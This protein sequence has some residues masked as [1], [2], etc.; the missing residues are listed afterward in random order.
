LGITATA[1]NDQRGQIISNG[2]LELNAG[3]V[4][5][6]SANTI[7]RQ[8]T[9]DSA[10]FS[11]R[12]GEI[13]QTGTAIASITSTGALDN[14]AGSIASNGDTRINAQSLNNQGGA[15]Q[16]TGAAN[17]NVLTSSA[18]D[19]SAGGSMA[20]GG[21][22]TLGASS[23]NNSQGQISEGGRLSTLASGATTNTQGLMAANGNASLT[24]ANLDNSQGT[25]ASVQEKVNVTT[26]GS[27]VNDS[28]RIQAAGD[29]ALRN[30]GLSNSQVAGA[31]QAGSITGS[32]ITIETNGQ[33]LN[34][35]GGTIA[36]AQAATLQTGALNNDAGLIQ[37]GAALSLDTQGQT[38]RNTNAAGYASGAGGITAQG[39]LA[40]NSGDM[41][42]D[43][44][45]IGA[46]GAISASSAKVSNSAGG[47]IVGE[48][49]IDFASTGFDNRGGQVQALG[50]VRLDAAA[51]TIDNTGSLVRSAGNTTLNAAGLINS[52]SG[53]TSQGIEGNNVAITANTITNDSGA[54][55]ADS[56]AT[57]TSSGVVSNAGGLISAGNA[58]TLQDA[59]AAKTLAITNGT[60]TI[61]GG[62]SAS[63]NAASLSSDGKLLSKGDLSLALS[64]GF[65]NSGEVTANGSATISTLGNIA[66]SGKLQAGNT[67]AVTA[68]TIDNAATGDINAGTTKVT[69]A[70]VLTNRGVIDGITTEVNAGTLNNLGTGRMYGDQLSIAADTLNNTLES[71]TAATIAARNRLDIG[72]QTINNAEHALI[73]S[74]GDMAIGGNLDADRH[75]TGQADAVNNASAT[76]E[77]LGNLV[78]STSQLNN[79]DKHF[80]YSMQQTSVENGVTE[81]V[82]PTLYRVFTRTTISPVAN[83]GDPGNILAGGDIT[84]HSPNINNHLSHIVA[85]GVLASP[86][87]PLAD[88]GADGHRLLNTGV[89]AQK[90]VRDS[91]TT[92]A[93]VH[94]PES[95]ICWG[96]IT[97]DCEAAHDEWRTGPYDITSQST[98]T[99]RQ[100][101]PAQGSG[102][103]PPAAATPNTSNDTS[104]AGVVVA[105]VTPGVAPVATINAPGAPASVTG[106]AQIVRTSAPSTQLPNTSLFHVSSSPANGFLV[107]TDPRFANYKT[108]VGSDYLLKALNIDP[109]TLHKRLGDGF[110]EQ[111]L[112]R[113]QVTKLT[114]QRFAGDYSTDEAQ[115]RALMDNGATYAKAHQ[116][117]PG[118]ALTPAQMAQLTSDIVWL[119][120]REVT[121]PDGSKTQAL[122]PQVYVRVQPGDLDGSGALLAGRE[123]NINT[124]GDLTNSGTI[125]GRTVV[126]LSAENVQN[127]G[128]RISGDA[129]NVAARNDLDNIGGQI[130]AKSSLAVNAG[131]DLNL[132]STTSSATNQI[133]SNT[134]SR[135]G[136]DRVAGL[137]VSKPGGT[138]LASA[139]RDAN[140]VGGVIQSQGSA[141]V[142]AGNNLNLKT[143]TTGNANSVVWDANNRVSDSQS[144]EL[145]SQ[146]QA[147]GNL[148][149]IAGQDLNAR[150]A[151]MQAG[152]ALQ[153]SA[154]HDVNLT[155]G[156]ATQSVDE[157][158][159]VKRQGFLS[160]NTATSRSTRDDSTAQVSNLAGNSVTVL[161]GNN[162]LLEGTQ[163]TAQKDALVYAGNQLIVSAARDSSNQSASSETLSRGLH[164]SLGAVGAQ[165]GTQGGGNATSS[166]TSTARG[167]QVSSAQGNASL[168]GASL[169]AVEGASLSAA[170]GTASITGGSV[171]VQGAVN[172]SSSTTSSTERGAKINGIGWSKTTE[173]INHKG[174]SSTGT[175]QTSLA[176]T[177]LSGQNASIVATD[178][179]AHIAGTRITT[180]GTLTLGASGTLHLDGQ[181][182]EKISSTQSQSR[183]LVY[184]KMKD[185]GSQ[186]QSTEYNQFHA[187]T[188]QV[189][190]PRISAQI[191]SKDSAQQLAQ[192]PGMQWVGQLTNDPALEGKVNWTQLQDA[193]RDWNY[194]QQGLTPEGAA[195]V[196]VVVAFFTYGAASSAGGAVAAGAGFTG[197]GATVVA[198]ATTAAITTLAAQAAVATL[199]H[200]DDPGAALKELGSSANTR[201][202]VTAMLTGG[203][204]GSLNLTPTGSPTVGG[205]AQPFMTQLGQNLQAGVA[206]SLISTAINGGSLED[207]LRNAI[208][209]AFID[210]GA[211]QGA[212]AIGEAGLDAFTN[213]VAHAIAGCV[214]GAARG[215]ASDGC[216]AGALG[217]A[218]GEASAEW[219]GKRDD[220]VQ[221]AAMM[222]AIGAA[223][224]GGDASQIN[225][226]SQTGGNAAANNYLKH[227]EASRL[228]ALLDK[229]LVGRCDSA[230][231]QEISSLQTLDH[232]RNQ[233]LDNCT[234]VASAACDTA[235]QAV[236]SA[237]A[238]YV[239]QNNNSPDLTYRTEAGE[240]VSLALGTLS[241]VPSAA[242]L[243]LLTSIKDGIVAL[244]SAGYTAFNALVRQ[245]PQAQQQVKE[246]AGAAWAF[247][248]EPANW[249]ELMGA[250]SGADRERLAKA[251]E[252]GDGLAVGQLLGAQVANLPVGGGG[253]GTIKKIDTLLEA[254]AAAKMAAL[255][256]E[257]LAVVK[258]NVGSKGSWEKAINGGLE[259]KAAYVL[260]NGHTYVTDTSGRV[261][262][263]VGEL[264]LRKMDRNTY[265][266]CITGKCGDVGDQGGHLIAATLGGAGDRINLVPQS[267]TLNNG[268]WK[269]MENEFKA[270]MESGKKV[271]IKID[272]GYPPG[273]GV[274]PDQFRVTTVIDGKTLPPR[275]FNQ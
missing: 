238:E 70:D 208:T 49:G 32:D 151:T 248:S 155:A 257:G 63:V 141:Q 243:G 152:Q 119:V 186:T 78:I 156:A 134:F 9:I 262:A 45:F 231:N 42:N 260:D 125:A 209:S 86:D 130:S 6:D 177:T 204:L 274:R 8:V 242:A 136:L 178:G 24:S 64:A 229:K 234:G 225:L 33:T 128:G 126:N 171:I 93:L 193:S 201:A 266:Q 76:V 26:S 31:S 161:A 17:L 192:Q 116:L 251:Y 69:A 175:E 273:G 137:Y 83:P 220:T 109:D 56:N 235:R 19:N 80:S 34:N 167:A 159:R 183:D 67:L 89:D 66:N 275:I 104:A 106:S 1:L 244:G 158:H 123:V 111:R 240:T 115:Y 15:I 142:T 108:W 13:I 223:A 129:V 48:S 249:P 102:Q 216:A 75:A 71:G 259:P 217:A 55:R 272:L 166:A 12:G 221:F 38:L 270:A 90:L 265:Q 165:F 68:G 188:V 255:K 205:G 103:Q 261:N 227:A 132:V 11:N 246:G 124:R 202:L 113:E 82:S 40:L 133:G 54:I 96:W 197:A 170:Q 160:S 14:T 73:F 157:A 258:V 269:T 16:A 92:Y 95:G 105:A 200:P 23:L 241:G 94:V 62:Q 120:E 162:A 196:T 149:L 237:A 230:C 139:G 72:A 135:T 179:D 146:V 118:I 232:Q 20:A 268:P 189:N 77:A 27:T 59:A 41:T 4:N 143:I 99:V 43:A 233:Q 173:G 117:H 30:A 25:I 226:A 153:L 61:I 110:Y 184:Q 236:R 256:A 264:D 181:Q 180:P 28:G 199:N 52:N 172:T 127:L 81:T 121:L 215:G 224:A 250:M 114:G 245:D 131:R 219:Y 198:G 211:A 88:L 176:R 271:S 3:S 7:A 21:N 164:L 53:S 252:S 112:V 145:G 185:S 87:S 222:S 191:G 147:A 144:V 98:V 148:T 51:G 65:I 101:T 44:G 247:V 174:Q 2:A 203:V 39:S 122:V 239:R 163:I 218:I 263:V 60:G 169:A 138:L 212:F 10:A 107:E 228:A 100:T 46:K 154:G 187:A 214:A 37:A 85:G 35:A 168:Y 50:D 207:S 253:M 58:A 254:A 195:I 213:K 194:K 79:T 57:L 18:L 84:L 182:T 47:Q 36:A 5:H 190:A 267:A 150:A 140:I 97:V 74:G 91:G 210:T 206:R 29:V 22:V